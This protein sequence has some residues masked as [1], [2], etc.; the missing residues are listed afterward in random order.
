MMFFKKLN[1]INKFLLLI[2]IICSLL[3]FFSLMFFTKSII[4]LSGIETFIRIILLIVFFLLFFM[5]ILSSLI[6]LFTGKNKTFLSITFLTIIFSLCF[7]IAAFYIDKTYNK[8][9]GLNKDETVYTSVLLSLN[10]TKFT[11]NKNTSVGMISDEDDI[12]GNKLA[13]KL[14]EKYNLNKIEIEE[15]DNYNDMINDLYDKNIEGIFVSSNYSILFGEEDFPTLDDDTKEIYKYNKKI[16]KDEDTSN[17]NKTLTEPFSILLI[18]VDSTSNNLKANQAFNG[19]TLMLITFNPNTLNATMF[20]IPRDTWTPISCRNN[21]KDKINKSAYGGTSCVVETIEN[22]TD[23]NVDYYVKMNFKGVVDLVNALGG[24][25][26]DVPKSFC[27]QNSDREWG[28]K[29]ICLKKGTGLLNGEQALALARNR[30]AFVR[31]DFDRVQHQQLIV[32]AIV[33]K[34]KDIRSVNGFYKILDAISNNVDTNMTTDQMLSFYEVGKDVLKNK[35]NGENSFISIE[36]TELTGYSRTIDE[37]YTF[38]YY[39]DSIN[40]INN[41]MKVNLEKTKPTLIK[42][43]SFSAKS[44]Y[45]V[46]LIGTDVKVT[47]DEKVSSIETNTV[48]E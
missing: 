22:L 20:S 31:A 14:I 9:S 17:N 47:S 30:H 40:Q 19:D 26:V 37:A 27:E 8:I 6:C 28:S 21:K 24:I 1:R 13:K 41:L 46:K 38:Q 29:Q 15:Y 7:S 42:T 43:F 5:Y 33:K 16:S 39:K 18:G 32:E 2:F 4:N 36:K 11:N 48:K 10:D 35:L 34:A 3:Y 44:P 12:E 23:V 45:E 25:T